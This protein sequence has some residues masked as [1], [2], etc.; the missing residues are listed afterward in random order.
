MLKHRSK[1]ALGKL[2]NKHQLGDTS[3]FCVAASQQSL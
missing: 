1:A 2:Q 3:H